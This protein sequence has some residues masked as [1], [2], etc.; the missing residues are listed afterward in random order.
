MKDSD[1]WTDYL[2]YTILLYTQIGF[3]ILSL[4][5]LLS[6]S[7]SQMCLQGIHTTFFIYLSSFSLSYFQP[8]NL[9][10]LRRYLSM[11]FMNLYMHILLSFMQLWKVK[12]SDSNS[13]VCQCNM[14][15]VTPRTLWALNNLCNT[16]NDII[17]IN[18]GSCSQL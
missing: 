2:R 3:R 1:A 10:K 11:F 18:H 13:T 8:F 15:Q 7:I 9:C 4:L 17:I 5:A 6:L 12:I 16:I 14:Y